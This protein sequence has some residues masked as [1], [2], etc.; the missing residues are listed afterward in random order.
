MAPSR[1]PDPTLVTCQEESVRLREDLEQLARGLHPRVLSDRGLAVALEQLCSHSPVPVHV[2]VPAG[3]FPERT[4]TTVWY[5]CA[6]ALANVWKHAVATQVVVQVE[7]SPDT[8][9]AVVRDDG[10]GGA[11]LSPGGGLAGLV[12]RVSGVGG[13]LSLASTTAGTHVTIEVPCR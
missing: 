7:A 13:R 5:A 3:R 8:L 11:R 2:H 1:D 4:E 9:T 10:V 6:E 12:D